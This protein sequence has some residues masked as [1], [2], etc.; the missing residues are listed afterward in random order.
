METTTQSDRTW[1]AG[2]VTTLVITN[3]GVL[4]VALTYL[5]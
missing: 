2:L 3:I 1:I 4:W 5:S